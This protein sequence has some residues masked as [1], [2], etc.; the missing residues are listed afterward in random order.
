MSEQTPRELAAKAV[1]SA[2]NGLIPG[3]GDG[4]TTV[5]VKHEHTRLGRPGHDTWSS[6]TQGFAERL[7][8]VLDVA[9]LQPLLSRITELEKRPT[10]SE[11]LRGAAPKLDAI[12]E[13]Y[14]VFG[15]GSRL[16]KMSSDP[17]AFAPRTE[18]SRWVDI[19][20]TLNAAHAAGMPVGIDL[21]GTLTDHRGWSVVWDRNTER[22]TVAGY[23][24]TEST[25]AP[26]T[27]CT[28]CAH[29]GHTLNW[30]SHSGCS[31]GSAP[32]LCGC[33]TFE[34]KQDGEG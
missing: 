29:C 13:Q 6:D 16:L 31:A 28:A 32:A 9:I 22:W 33:R 12:C 34:A 18:R 11:V 2:L 25:L 17:E 30:H 20:A 14:G 27:L 21:D 5:E 23:E 7:A 15:A 8:L 26:V 4:P 19:A 24:D 10:P 3:A 1:L